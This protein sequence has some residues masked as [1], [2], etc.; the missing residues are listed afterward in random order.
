MSKIVTLAYDPV[1]TPL[2]WAKECCPSYIT[3]DVHKDEFNGYDN[4]KID[5][6]FSDEEDAFKFALRW[7]NERI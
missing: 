6:F 5:Y 1:W 7:G 3:N 4:D 2:T